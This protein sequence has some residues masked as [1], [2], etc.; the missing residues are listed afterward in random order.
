[1]LSDV[2]MN[3]GGIQVSFSVG[4]IPVQGVVANSIQSGKQ[5]AEQVVE[6]KVKE[7]LND[8]AKNTRDMQKPSGISPFMDIKV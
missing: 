2:Y 7:V 6:Q 5:R 1:M 4:G 3:R 8:P